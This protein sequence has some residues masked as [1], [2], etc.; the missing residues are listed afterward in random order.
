LLAF[1]SSRVP[2]A[3]TTPPLSLWG[4]PTSND[5]KFPTIKNTPIS[6]YFLPPPP[7]IVASKYQEEENRIS[8]ALKVYQRDKI[9]N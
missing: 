8:M 3:L 1:E 4:G 9:A 5:K 2:V 6:Y 7:T